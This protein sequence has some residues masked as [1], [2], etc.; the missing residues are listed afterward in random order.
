MTDLCLPHQ[1]EL[2]DIRSPSTLDVGV[3]AVQLRSVEL[4]R[5]EEIGGL[6]RVAGAQGA[7]VPGQ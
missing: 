3:P 2:E 6:G 1:P 7:G 5:L 4:V